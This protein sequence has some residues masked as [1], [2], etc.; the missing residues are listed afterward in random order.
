MLTSN[1]KAA[2]LPILNSIGAYVYLVDV[3]DDGTFRI[4]AINWSDDEDLGLQD[5]DT[6]VGKRPEEV[7]DAKR[8]ARLNEHYRRCVQTRL[9]IEFEGSF[10][11][12]AGPRWTNHRIMGTVVDITAR[13]Q[14]E[15]ALRES[16][17]RY[18][19]L[20]DDN[21]AKLVTLAPDGEIL[22]VNKFGAQNSG[23]ASA[24][25]VGRSILEYLHPE[26]VA[27]AKQFLADIMNY[28]GRVHRAEFRNIKKDGSVIWLNH[29]ACVTEDA[30]GQPVILVVAEETTETHEL[31]EQLAYQASHDSLTGLVNRRA[32]EQR[33]LGL[34]ESA[35]AEKVEHALCYL[36]LDQFKIINDTC[37][38]IAGDELLR[39][40]GGRLQAEIRPQDT[41]AR[42]GGD[43]FGVL[44]EACTLEQAE[45]VS[46]QLCRTIEDFHF[47]WQG[48][49]FTIGVSIG[50]VPITQSSGN[51]TTVLSAAD[52]ACYA[53][54]E[55]GRNR[56]H[57]YR[58]DDREL[59]IRHTEMEWVNRLCNALAEDRLYL[60]RQ[61]IA[62][63][64]IEDQAGEHY[65]L[66]LR[67][68]D[69]HGELVSYEVCLQAAERYNLAT[70]LDQWVV[71]N[72]FAW[73][74]GSSERLEKLSLCAINLSG[75]TLSDETFLDFVVDQFKHT[76]IPP[77]KICFE[78]TETA[79]ITNL[80]RAI[81]FI[82]ALK[83]LGCQ[84]ALDDFGSGMSSLSYLK[85]LPVD[86]L[87]IDGAFV[88]D[89]AH[90]P[91]DL[92]VV[93]SINDIGHVM[94]KKTIAEFV[95]NDLILDKLREIGVDFFQGYRIGRPEPIAGKK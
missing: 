38:H 87:K 61:P 56:V 16:Q 46:Q 72:A 60:F 19:A 35:V 11:S 90:D 40:L 20:Y 81:G 23:Y 59:A 88:Q 79:A 64:G 39:Q 9:N 13:K 94:G 22:S 76:G 12:S 48:Q 68:E 75:C 80:T 28:P 50:V 41:L 91:V 71:K 45:A 44:M 43:E 57:V 67:L 14:V 78:I 85:Q 36:D 2:V 95:E 58:E 83:A 93:K 74:S 31:A 29:T 92:A 33:L 63:L 24:D 27:A 65:E 62:P 8:A 54:K 26:D 10:E 86:Y 73:L 34:L 4:F 7:L 70:R 15:G 51:L 21:P 69:E 49:H 6:I 17:A 55:K 1:D 25:L 53:A 84:F 47:L 66:L 52:R 77:E 37:G 32:F 89:I 82:Q 42:L 30:V 5:F 18:H 3:L